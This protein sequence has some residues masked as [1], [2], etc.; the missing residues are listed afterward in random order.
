MFLALALSKDKLWSGTLNGQQTSDRIGMH[1]CV[2][3]CAVFGVSSPS[4]QVGL[5]VDCLTPCDL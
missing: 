4:L 5:P 3:R 2:L 1:V